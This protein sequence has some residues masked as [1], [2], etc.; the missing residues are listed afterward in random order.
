MLTIWKDREVNGECSKAKGWSV[1]LED[2]ERSPIK[3]Q[4]RS[5]LEM[6]TCSVSEEKQELL[7]L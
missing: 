6:H 3:Q 5:N 4:E 2:E 7:A 1:E